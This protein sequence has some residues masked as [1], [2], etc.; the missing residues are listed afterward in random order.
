MV[1]EI[2]PHVEPNCSVKVKISGL[3]PSAAY[4]CCTQTQTAA[5]T[6]L[7]LPQS[8]VSAWEA[9]SGHQHSAKACK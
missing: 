3:H 2:E 6:K 1:G 4:F 7:S 5:S 8:P 9:V